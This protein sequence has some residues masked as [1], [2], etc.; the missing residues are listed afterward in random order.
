MVLVVYFPIKRYEVE[1]KGQKL[2]WINKGGASPH[3]EAPKRGFQNIAKKTPI[4]LSKREEDAAVQM[5]KV[6]IKDN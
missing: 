6:H 4:L 5:H 2:H 3:S 1:E